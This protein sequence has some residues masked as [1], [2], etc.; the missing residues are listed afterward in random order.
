[1][2]K[3]LS[4]LLCSTLAFASAIS[5][6]AASKPAEYKGFKDLS[7]TTTIPDNTVKVYAYN[8][9]STHT[10][11]IRYKGGDTKQNYSVLFK[12]CINSPKTMALPS[13]EKYARYFTSGGGN[14]NPSH[15]FA[16]TGGKYKKIRIKLSEFDD[17]FNEDGSHTKS[18]D[19]STPSTHDFKFKYE[20]MGNG[21]SFNSALVIISGGAVTGITPNK[22]GEAEF[23]VST[24]VGESVDMMTKFQYSTKTSSGG[25]GGL[26]G[27]SI[28]SKLT[29]GNVDG[30]YWVNV[31]DVT[32]L[33]LYLSG[34]KELDTLGLFHADVDCDGI[35]DVCD[36]TALQFG[37][38]SL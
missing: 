35:N 32:A 27:G 28:S 21:C 37:I 25:G 7:E 22:N 34:Q 4:V 30:D 1:M 13:T 23:F 31:N 38:A 15:S 2:K 3:I 16:T 8:I 20:D 19:I 33:Q 9:D 12:D 11:G 10:N 36:V 14:T 29:F 24:D 26:T 5:A 17:Y 18:Y 6:N